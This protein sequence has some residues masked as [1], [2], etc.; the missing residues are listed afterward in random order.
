MTKV[1]IIL[2]ECMFKFWQDQ[3]GVAAV[4]AACS[5]VVLLGFSALVLDLGIA[6]NEASKLQNA[7]DSAALAGAQELPA[8]NML[9]SQWSA[10]KNEAKTYAA[11]N[12]YPISDADI[13]PVYKDDISTNQI[14]GLK[15][16][17]TIDVE[18]NFAKVLG[19]NSGTIVRSAGAGLAP[20]GGIRHAVPLSITSSSL[21]A[22]INAGV[23]DDLLIKCSPNTDDIG[24]DNDTISGW[25]AP[26][27]FDGSGASVYESLISYG[28]DGP[29]YVGQVLDVENG[30]MSGP[31][32]DGFTTRF[33]AC[34]DGCTPESFEPD[35]PRL[36]YI[37]VI[38][39]LD[40]HRV[41]VDA[42]AAFFL[43]ECGGN[44]NNS[45]IKATYIP[46]NILPNTAAGTSGQDFGI[47]VT[48]LFD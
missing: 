17:K 1:V 26:L 6:Y 32:L 24:I 16:T 38:S 22:A 44:G 47:Y 4:I 37:P 21:R 10:A 28:F 20:A 11:A 7:L 3:R 48:R 13:T 14:I 45:Y 33:D 34:S 18:Y 43:T 2:K 5:L 35:C 42:F 25:F 36:I 39:I 40:N 30:N 9:S 31:T 27:R 46:D 15:V 12:D 8:A 23:T 29:L 41:R 19:I